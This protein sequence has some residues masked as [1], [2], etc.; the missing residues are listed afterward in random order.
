MSLA[1]RGQS[2]GR[3]DSLRVSASPT[4]GLSP[5]SQPGPLLQ[6]RAVSPPRPRLLGLVLLLGTLALTV[7]YAD[8]IRTRFLNDDYL[9]LEQARVQDLGTSLTRPDPLS[10]YWRPLSRQLWFAALGPIAGGNPL[11]FHVANYLLF[12]AGLAL[13]AD[14][15]LVFVPWPGVL[16]GLVTFALL[17]FQR[18]NL[19]WVSCSQDLLALVFALGAFALY[20]RRR[21]RSAAFLYLLAVLSKESALPLPLALAAWSRLVEREDWRVLVRRVAPF[22]IG[23]GVWLAAT[24]IL[25]RTIGRVNAPLDFGA[26]SF[27]AGYLHMLQSLLGLDNP[28][29]FTRRYDLIYEPIAIALLALIALWLHQTRGAPPAAENLPAPRRPSTRVAIQ[30]AAVWLLAFGFVTG[31]AAPS[32]SAYYYTLAAAGGVVLISLVA[33]RIGAAGWLTLLL[34]LFAVHGANRGARTFALEPNPWS[35]TSHLTPWYFDR[36]AAYADTFSHQMLALE[37]HPPADTRFFFSMLPPNAGF[38]MGNGALIRALYREPKIESYFLSQFDDSTAGWHPSRFLYWD[39]LSIVPLYDMRPE[40]NPF[41]QVGTDLILL[42]RPVGAV[43][44]FHR[45]LEAGETPFNHLYWLGWAE[46]FRG[47][48]TEAEYAWLQAGMREDSLAW[49][50]QMRIARQSLNDQGDTLEARRA[51]ARALLTGPGRP[52]TH[53]VLGELLMAGYA[54]YGVLELKVACWLKPGDWYARRLLAIGL[55]DHRLDDPAR[56]ELAVL[57]RIHP[58]WAADTVLVAAARDLERRTGSIPAVAP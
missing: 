28:A 15:L 42:D 7:F 33:R 45:G 39:G 44:A 32:W 34:A 52:E 14:L 31:P 13:L 48:R 54:K 56:R 24:V 36:A 46:M 16:A 40:R 58:D 10:N 2:G 8:A 3:R 55:I 43:H 21:D 18:V 57:K 4:R 38:Q 50:Q 35:W 22:T 51:L 12:L 25:H 26:G 30:F 1:I 6:C 17:P 19:T 11:V 29:M 53:A 47:R 37:P 5:K 41:F 20:R 23:V 27:V 49:Y 9:L